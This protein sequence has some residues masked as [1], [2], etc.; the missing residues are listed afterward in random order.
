VYARGVGDKVLDFSH[1]GWLYEETFLFY[2]YET[3]SLW[4]Q[5]TG[6]AVAGAYK[7][8]Y[9]DRLPSLQ[10]TWS[11]WKTLQPGTQVLARVLK[12]DTAYWRDSYTSYYQTGRGIKYQRFQQLNFGVAV[13]LPCG[14]KL[15]P[16]REL[17]KKPV[18][19]DKVAGEPVVVI[20]HKLSQTA[21][22]FD[23]RREGTVFDFDKYQVE[24]SDIHLTD[25]QTQS[26]WSGLSGRCLA[27]PAKGAQLRQ[28]TTTQWVV[29]NWPLHYPKGAIY[30]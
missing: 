22:A 20:Y 12:G 4:A 17:E 3:D 7:A 23:P 10:T 8:T 18:I 19:A 30:R 2:D 13:V 14:Q 24:K 9:L 6:Q 16:F 15:Y 11:Q 29:E 21:L 26:T 27:G 1:R 5:A 25:K 28:L